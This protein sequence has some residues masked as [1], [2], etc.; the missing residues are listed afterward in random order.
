MLMNIDFNGIKN[1]IISA[2]Q[3]ASV[4]VVEWSGRGVAVLKSG[5]DMA[6][7]YLQDKRIAVASLIGVTLILIE[8]GDLFGRLLTCCVPNETNGQKGFREIVHFI[9]GAG[10]LGAGVAAFSKHAK[11]PLG[12]LAITI[13]TVATVILRAACTPIK[14]EAPEA[15]DKA[16]SPK[17][18][19]EAK[20][21]QKV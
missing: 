17:A 21:E 8:V 1:A 7:P 12:W 19:T 10:I 9:V 16:E 3:T 18:K 6:L 4:K 14:K 11:L 13:T 5:S 15:A 2:Y 20:V